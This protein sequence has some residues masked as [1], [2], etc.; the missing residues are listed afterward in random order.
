MAVLG[1]ALWM[2]AYR[3]QIIGFILLIKYSEFY[4]ILLQLNWKIEKTPCCYSL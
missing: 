2:F 1:R 3:M 4:W